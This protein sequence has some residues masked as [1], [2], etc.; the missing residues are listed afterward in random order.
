M[1]DSAR[2][3]DEALALQ[4]R[5]EGDEAVL[6]KLV[7]AAQADP[8]F[9][10]A[11]VAVKAIRQRRN[12]TRELERFFRRQVHAIIGRSHTAEERRI[13]RLLWTELAILQRVLGNEQGAADC[14]KQAD[15][16]LT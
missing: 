9:E 14:Q 10:P 7:E 15:A 5:A 2:L 8:F 11:Y 16:L 13:Q 6:D 1:A 12:E 4:Q 3:Y